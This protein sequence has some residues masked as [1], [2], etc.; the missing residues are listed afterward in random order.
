MICRQ[1][2]TLRN[3]AFQTRDTSSKSKS[4][5]FL[6]ID[7]K[8]SCR[9]NGMKKLILLNFFFSPSDTRRSFLPLTVFALFVFHFLLCLCSFFKSFFFFFFFCILVFTTPVYNHRRLSPAPKAL[10]ISVVHGRQ[11]LE[12]TNL[13]IYLLTLTLA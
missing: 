3:D 7:Q 13:Y 6:E 4:Y 5:G 12:C 1:E 9:G 10:A 11:A 8:K 2:I